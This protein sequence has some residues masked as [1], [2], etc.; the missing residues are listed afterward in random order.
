MSELSVPEIYK[1]LLH[2]FP[3][4]S[5]SWRVGSTSQDKTKGIALAYIDARD[6]MRRLDDV[7][8]FNN[9]QDKYEDF[10]KTTICYLSIKIN[11]E[12]VTKADGAGD[13]AVEEEKGRISDAF[14]R[15]AVKWGIGRYLY[16]LDSPWVKLKDKRI[17][18]SEYDKLNKLLGM[19]PKPANNAAAD[20]TEEDYTP[21]MQKQHYNEAM[22]ALM[23][24]TT[25]TLLQKYWNDRGRRIANGLKAVNNME[26]HD[27][28]VAKK[29]ELK[30]FFKEHE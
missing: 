7:V 5:V 10:G 6:V 28:L 19:S 3:P 18:P 24:C 25:T 20:L 15:S 14:K 11:G 2:P 4:E 27:S 12:W 22:E 30:L 13:T 23:N 29:D 8:G 21:E 26:L 1:K 9:W 16:D 17:D